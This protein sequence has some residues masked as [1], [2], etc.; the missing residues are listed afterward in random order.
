MG[1]SCDWQR[2]RFTLDDVCA[3]RCA[4]RSSRCSRRAKSIAASGWS[5]GIR[6]CRRPSA[7]MK[8]ST[9]PVKGH[10]WHFRY[11][12]GQSEAGRAD[13]R[14]HRH[15]AARNDVG[16]YGRGRAS[17]SRRRTEQARRRASATFGRRPGQ[18]EAGNSGP[19]RRRREP[20]SRNA[21]ATRKTPRHGPCRHDAGI[22]A[23]RP[24]RFR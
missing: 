9:R 22:A 20:P 23:N 16:R 13:A 1:C 4:R 24:A 11:P 12:V 7:T 6:S 5:I 19:N 21:A 14:D 15:H 3:G 2:T 10:F 8:S 17:R 18:G